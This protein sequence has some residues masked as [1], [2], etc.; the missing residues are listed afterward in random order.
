MCLGQRVGT[1]K[2]A[3]GGWGFLVDWIG[4]GN[5]LIGNGDIKNKLEKRGPC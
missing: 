3:L 4:R 5:I 1:M 2:F